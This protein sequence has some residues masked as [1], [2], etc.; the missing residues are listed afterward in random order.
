[1]PRDL[2]PTHQLE[3]EER[4]RK[5]DEKLSELEGRIDKK[6]AELEKRMDEKLAHQDFGSFK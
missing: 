1:M 6:L 5:I 4:W 2:S 3:E